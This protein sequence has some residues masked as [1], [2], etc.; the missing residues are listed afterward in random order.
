MLKKILSVACIV[1][2]LNACIEES[3]PKHDIKAFTH[4]YDH[5]SFNDS[6]YAIDMKQ[7]ADGG[8]LILGSRTGVFIE[9]GETQNVNTPMTPYLIKTDAY[10]KLVNET[11]LTDALYYPMGNL[12]E[13]DG[14]YYFFCMDAA[15]TAVL[16]NVD[17]NGDVVSAPVTVN[18]LIFPLASATTANST[19]LL[20]LSYDN[21][22]QETVASRVSVSG[23][24]SASSRFY[25][26]SGSPIDGLVVAH[27]NKEG[28]QYPFTIGQ[29]QGGLVYFNGFIDYTLALVFTNLNGN[30]NVVG[31]IYGVQANA[32]FSTVLP[33]G[34]STFAI[35]TYNFGF[36][37]LQPNATLATNQTNGSVVDIQENSHSF[38]ELEHNARVK[39]IPATIEGRNTVV[40]A[41]NTKAG[42]IGLYVYDRTTGEFLSGKYVG[43]ANPF[44]IGALVQTP[45]GDLV[46][47]GTTYIAGR[48]PRLCLIKIPQNE[49]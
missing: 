45:E 23:S 35:A 15:K 27:A 21:S 44:V 14:S 17:A 20:L 2:T 31:R 29:T 4:I 38:P 19:A 8:Y 1:F 42:Q 47:S 11:E 9:N 36:N 13:V 3:S 25:T 32:G 46:L 43:Y 7:T 10:G 33:T 6:F 5:S 12:N 24:V 34:T 40:Y 18:D 22:T 41:S 28:T 26:G 16:V 30:E 48:L 39:V 49:L 37:F